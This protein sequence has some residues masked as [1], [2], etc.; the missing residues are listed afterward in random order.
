MPISCTHTFYQALVDE[1]V[2][3]P[4]LALKVTMTKWVDKRYCFQGDLNATITN[5]DLNGHT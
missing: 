4:K 1:N 5:T 3:L 2:V